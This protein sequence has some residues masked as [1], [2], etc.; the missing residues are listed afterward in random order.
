MRS[1]QKSYTIF[2]RSGESDRERKGRMN[3]NYLD[4][5]GRQLWIFVTDT[6]T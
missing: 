2:T 5:K 1:V 6:L 3:L 4:G